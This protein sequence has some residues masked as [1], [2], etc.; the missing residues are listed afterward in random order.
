MKQVLGEW[1][2]RTTLIAALGWIGW[3]LHQIRQ[4]MLLPADEQA[5]TQAGPSDLQDSIDAL[6]DD[7]A[8][9]NEKVDAMMLAMLQ[10]KR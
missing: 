6:S 9:L 2:W 5:T 10:L 4:E 1:L 3:E 8:T 7:V